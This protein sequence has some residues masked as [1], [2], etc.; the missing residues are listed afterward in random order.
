[1]V[2]MCHASPL[3]SDSDEAFHVDNDRPTNETAWV[4]RYLLLHGLLGIYDV[5]LTPS[6][7]VQGHLF[8]V[9]IDKVHTSFGYK[10]NRSRGVGGHG[11]LDGRGV[12]VG[13]ARGWI[14]QYAFPQIWHARLASS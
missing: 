14:R 5:P 8:G 12:R 6:V 11:G 13:G 2:P 1:M 9:L 4:D 7:L 3:S 10:S